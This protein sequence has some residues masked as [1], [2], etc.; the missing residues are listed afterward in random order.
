MAGYSRVY[1]MNSHVPVTLV[2]RAQHV[3]SVSRGT[4]L[5]MIPTS[6]DVY[7]F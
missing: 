6:A 7:S 1:S 5:L 2:Q 3:D 4:L